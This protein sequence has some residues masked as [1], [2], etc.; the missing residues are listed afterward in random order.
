MNFMTV[1]E[2]L[3]NGII[4][5][6]LEAFSWIVTILFLSL[7]I[8]AVSKG[9]TKFTALILS[10]ITKLTKMMLE[11]MLFLIKFSVPKIFNLLVAIVAPVIKYF[12]WNLAPR[13]L[14]GFVSLTRKSYNYISSKLKSTN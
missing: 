5:F 10:F 9:K 4:G 12:G 14:K 6:G 3:K 13:F 11:G 2:D 7:V 1:F 8:D